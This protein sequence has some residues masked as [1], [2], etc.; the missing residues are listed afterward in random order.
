MRALLLELP[1]ELQFEI[2][3]LLYEDYC[4]TRDKEIGAC[5]IVWLWGEPEGWQWRGNSL[6]ALRLYVCFLFDGPSTYSYTG[7]VNTSAIYAPPHYFN[8][9]T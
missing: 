9:W 7:P 8:V 2:I 3:K 5:R 4:V 6:R 1:L